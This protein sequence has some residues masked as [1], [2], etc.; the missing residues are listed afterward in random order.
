[1]RLFQEIEK[2]EPDKEV[3]SGLLR[4]GL[5]TLKEIKTYIEEQPV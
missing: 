3:I 2:E 4:E 1:M 5:T